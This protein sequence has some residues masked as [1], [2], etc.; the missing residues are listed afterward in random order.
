M[1]IEIEN[2]K[3]ERIDDHKI[4]YLIPKNFSALDP[5]RTIPI[6]SETIIERYE[7]ELKRCGSFEKLPASWKI[8]TNVVYV[9]VKL[10]SPA[11]VH[12]KALDTTY[13]MPVAKVLCKYEVDDEMIKKG[14]L[15]KAIVWAM[16]YSPEE[17]AYT[18]SGQH[19]VRECPNVEIDSLRSESM[20]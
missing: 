16:G 19:I 18:Y 11:I 17:A 7:E 1:N 2:I 8:F 5:V 13:E 14:K 15:D 9:D 6:F 4:M 12:D 10:K 3:I 20:M